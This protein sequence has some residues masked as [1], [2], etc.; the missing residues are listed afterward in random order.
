MIKK[1]RIRALVGKFFHTFETPTTDWGHV[2]WQG[3]IL[4]RPEP[5]L[6]LIQLYGWLDG[7]PSSQELVRLS[8][9]K[10]WQFY[11]TDDQMVEAYWDGNNISNSD[12]E[13]MRRI[14]EKTEKIYYGRD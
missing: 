14:R 1:I 5:G 4:S 3:Q 12:R 11:D 7:L 6:Y 8:D 9:K 13:F 10:H 2:E